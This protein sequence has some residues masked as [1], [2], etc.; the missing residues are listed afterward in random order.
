MENEGSRGEGR[1]ALPVPLLTA[2]FS[3]AV[4]FKRCG[5]AEGELSPANPASVGVRGGWPFQ[6]VSNIINRR[7]S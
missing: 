3:E 6:R 4:R 1:A 7:N 5:V 2:V